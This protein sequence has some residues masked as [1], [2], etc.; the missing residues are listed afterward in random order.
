MVKLSYQKPEV[1]EQLKLIYNYLPKP[2]L[3]F[4]INVSTNEIVRRLEARDKGDRLL[5]F[6]N[7]KEQLDKLRTEHI[8]ISKHLPYNQYI[9]DGERHP[10]DI[11]GEIFHIINEFLSKTL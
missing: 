11:V 9:I 4:L 3:S 1:Q 5:Y 8:Q 10:E 6:P 2:Q 7:Y